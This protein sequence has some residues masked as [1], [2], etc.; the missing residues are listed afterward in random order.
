VLSPLLTI[1]GGPDPD[2]TTTALWLGLEV[3]WW[4]GLSRDKLNLPLGE[5]YE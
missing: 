1:E 2:F 5:A 3:S 4:S